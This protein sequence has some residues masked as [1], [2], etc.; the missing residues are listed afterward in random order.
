MKIPHAGNFHNRKATGI[1]AMMVIL[2]LLAVAAV[3]TSLL[4][5]SGDV[6]MNPGP[7]R[8]PGKILQIYIN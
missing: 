8:Y 1:R 6:E 7:G 3:Q 5:R 4:L 2:L